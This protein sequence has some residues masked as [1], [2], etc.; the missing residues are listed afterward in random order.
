MNTKLVSFIVAGV[1]VAALGYL[2][3]SHTGAPAAAPT[4]Q[5][6]DGQDP[7]FGAT[8]TLDAVDNPFVSIGG[9]KFYYGNRAL[10]ATSSVVCSIKNP[11]SATS[12]VS[13]IS[14]S[15]PVNGLG[16][17]VLDVSTSSTAYASSSPAFV[18]GYSAGAP[19]FSFSWLGVAS[20]T[21]PLVIG[22]DQTGT[23]GISPYVVGP[24]EYVNFRI[25]TTAAGT[26]VTY[27]KGNCTVVFE[28]M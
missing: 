18:K 12:T 26:F 24:Q 8:A 15:V 23:T 13:G 6:Q 19:A 2:S 25:A 10:S 14:M 7:S 4:D 16:A 17:Q 5:P 27:Y 20:T 21:N 9:A 11:F 1:L 3:G 22:F 28:K